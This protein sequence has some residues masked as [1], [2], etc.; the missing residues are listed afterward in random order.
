MKRFTTI[1]SSYRLDQSPGAECF[2][3]CS[4]RL[5]RRS[6]SGGSIL[7]ERTFHPRSDPAAV[8]NA[9]LQEFVDAAIDGIRTAAS[10]LGVDLARYDVTVGEFLYADCDARHVAF[11]FAG[12]AALRAALAARFGEEGW[13]RETL[14]FPSEIEG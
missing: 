11:R 8:D 1:G 7:V 6:D 10:A 14:F 12:R 13:P 5:R 2:G 3:G 9:A 4:V